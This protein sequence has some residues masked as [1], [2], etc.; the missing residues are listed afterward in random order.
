APSNGPQY[1][2]LTVEGMEGTAIRHV[3][4]I[5]QENRTTDN[6]FQGL[7]IPP[8]GSAADCGT[9]QNQYDIAQQGTNSSGQTVKL[10]PMDLGKAGSIP[11]YY[12][13]GH[14]HS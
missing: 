10:A 8:Y 6:L 13:L 4:V 5:F 3:V 2:T 12:D 7:C 11:S 9:G 1:L 14:G